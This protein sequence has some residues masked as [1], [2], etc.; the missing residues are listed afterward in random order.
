MSLTSINIH[1]YEGLQ[2]SSEYPSNGNS[3]TL[4]G[5]GTTE[6]TF[7]LPVEQW[8]LLRCLPKA[9]DY[10]YAI[11]GEGLERD[12]GKADELARQ[13]FAAWAKSVAD[14]PQDVDAA[15]PGYQ[16]GLSEVQAAPTVT[17]D[18][19]GIEHGLCAIM[20]RTFDPT[21]K[22]QTRETFCFAGV[23]DAL[24]DTDIFGK[25]TSHEEARADF[26]KKLSGAKIKVHYSDNFPPIILDVPVLAEAAAP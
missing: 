5:P 11:K 10:A 3:I 25:G 17:L 21:S 16:P 7:Y 13:H 14:P 9:S 4:R 20:N 24:T 26:A 22:N 12:H 2:V 15:A 8:V 18:Q 23:R 19:F 6:V 1:A